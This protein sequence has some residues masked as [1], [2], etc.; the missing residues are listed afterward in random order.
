SSS[1]KSC[2]A[3]QGE[4]EYR[5]GLLW[6]RQR[7]GACFFFVLLCFI[8]LF[9]PKG[10]RGLLVFLIWRICFFRWDSFCFLV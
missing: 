7:L 2:T 4:G 10:A 9:F 6:P 8:F 1:I 5:A 3:F